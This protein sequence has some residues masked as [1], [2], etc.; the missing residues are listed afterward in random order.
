M[1][2]YRSKDAGTWEKQGLIL[3]SASNRLK[4]GRRAGRGTWRCDCSKREGLYI[5]LYSSCKKT[6]FDTHLNENGV[7]HF[8]DRRSSIQAAPPE[9]KD[10]TFMC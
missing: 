3:D 8:D 10:G 6:Y 5:L 4:T 1:R 7:Y 2:V 9:I